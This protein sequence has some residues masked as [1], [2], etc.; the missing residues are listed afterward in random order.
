MESD[1]SVLTYGEENTDGTYN[2]VGESSVVFGP[3]DSTDSW[4]TED[5]RIKFKPEDN[6]YYMFYTACNGN[7]IFLSL[8]TT[9]NPTSFDKWTNSGVITKVVADQLIYAPFT[10]TSYFAFNLVRARTIKK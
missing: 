6:L 3:S 5:P 1:A 7:S 10:I 4:G 8:A 2:F 9:P